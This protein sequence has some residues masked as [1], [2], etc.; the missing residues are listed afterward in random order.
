MKK[1][2]ILIGFLSMNFFSFPQSVKMVGGINLAKYQFSQNTFALT[3]NQKSGFTGGIAF[4]IPVSKILGIEAGLLYAKI[5]SGAMLAVAPNLSI[6]GIYQY[7]SLRFPLMLKI[8]ILPASTPYVL[9]GPEFSLVLSHKLKLTDTQETYDL[10][11]QTNHLG[12]G[13]HSGVGYA[14][15][16]NPI[17]AIFEIRYTIGLSNLYKSE[18]GLENVKNNSIQFLLGIQFNFP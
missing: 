8:N 7:T 10:K 15:Q 13:I 18:A 3:S 4:E 11:E 12:L 2:A 5:S 6:P 1:T 9:I 14:L 16:I 17:A